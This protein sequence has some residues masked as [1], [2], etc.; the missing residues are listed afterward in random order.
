MCIPSA[1][2]S[3]LDLNHSFLSVLVLS[4][5]LWIFTKHNTY[6]RCLTS[7]SE[8]TLV[9]TSGSKDP[10]SSFPVPGTRT[11]SQSRDRGRGAGLNWT[12][13]GVRCVPTTSV[14]EGNVPL[15]DTVSQRRLER[16]ATEAPKFRGKR[17][18]NGE[19]V[20]KFLQINY[21]PILFK[22][23]LL[24]FYPPTGSTCFLT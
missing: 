11:L 9:T 5:C 13:V 7:S 1:F 2:L 21:N 18:R 12:G 15:S 8:R 3:A 16:T 10:E 19:D 24:L 6:W 23:R 22:I 17:Q 20:C 4:L 14:V